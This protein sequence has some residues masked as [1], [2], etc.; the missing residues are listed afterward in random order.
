MMEPYGDAELVDPQGLLPPEQ[1]PSAIEKEEAESRAVLAQMHGNLRLVDLPGEEQGE[2]PSQD[3]DEAAI[4]APEASQEA[5]S[6]GALLE[7]PEDPF[8]AIGTTAQRFSEIMASRGIDPRR[9]DDPESGI[10]PELALEVLQENGVSG[11]NELRDFAD[12]LVETLQTQDEKR[13]QAAEIAEI[14]EQLAAAPGSGSPY[15]QLRNEM[16]ELKQLFLAREQEAQLEQQFRAETDQ[17]ID[18]HASA[19]ES[20]ITEARRRGIDPPDARAYENLYRGG[21]MLQLDPTL[22]ARLAWAALTAPEDVL[23]PRRG[24]DQ[25]YSRQNPQGVR[26]IR[27]EERIDPTYT[28]AQRER[29]LD[30][31]ISEDDDDRSQMDSAIQKFGG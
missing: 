20:L 8:G 18:L 1:E 14:R 19:W 23:G 25:P 26:V 31:L 4:V 17:R 27:G 30:D 28:P 22:A 24:R 9:F 11:E 3:M 7:A 15:D 6:L 29:S 12:R 21:A 2:P 16:A 13:A 10:T 5:G